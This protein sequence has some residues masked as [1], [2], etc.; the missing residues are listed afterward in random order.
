MYGPRGDGLSGLTSKIKVGNKF[1]KADLVGS[2]RGNG[3]PTSQ[4]RMAGRF[5]G[6]LCG[7]FPDLDIF[8]PLVMRP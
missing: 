3:C 4:C 1:F 7:L 2:F 8:I 5:W 6:G